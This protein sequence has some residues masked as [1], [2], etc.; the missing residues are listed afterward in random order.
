MQES[1]KE[2]EASLGGE[3]KTSGME[4]KLVY[5]PSNTSNVVGIVLYVIPGLACREGR[6][7][8][9]RCFQ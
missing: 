5:Y 3:S 8:A 4:Y 9:G 2:L 7:C 1:A 6:V